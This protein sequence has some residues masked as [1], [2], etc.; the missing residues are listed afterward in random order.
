MC[1]QVLFDAHH[2]N[3]LVPV[4]VCSLCAI[5]LDYLGVTGIQFLKLVC[6]KHDRIR[7]YSHVSAI[8]RVLNISSADFFSQIFWKPQILSIMRT[9]LRFGLVVMPHIT[10][11]RHKNAVACFKFTIKQ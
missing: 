3:E 6:C 2:V 7:R 10:F 5:H 1:P 11:H 4:D 8:A 9:I